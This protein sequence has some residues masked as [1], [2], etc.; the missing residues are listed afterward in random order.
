MAKEQRIAVSHLRDSPWE[1]RGLRGFLE[2]RDLGVA[3][4]TEG[5]FGATVAR[6]LHAHRPGADAPL[7]YHK[8]GFHFT[9]VLKGWMRTYMEG[10]G[11]VLLE[12]GDCITYEGEI[13]QAHVEYS[14]DYEVLQVTMPADFATVSVVP[15][16]K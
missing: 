3:G 13:N 15:D 8:I 2:Y 14:D 1:S 7:H 5:R 4:A 6:A 16:R 11:E 9:Y 10:L 12:A